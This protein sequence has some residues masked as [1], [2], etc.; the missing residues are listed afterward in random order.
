MEHC[1]R[2]L[3]AD[4]Y[5][6]GIEPVTIGHRRPDGG[7]SEADR[8]ACTGPSPSSRAAF[9]VLLGAVSLPFVVSAIALAT[10]TW[11][12]AGDQALQ[13]LRIEQVGTSRTPLLGPWSR[14][15]WNHPGPWPYY[16]LAPFTQAFGAVGALIGT[17][18]VNSTSLVLAVVVARR[19]GGL[20]AAGLVALLGML[21]GF[22]RGPT[23]LMDLWN[24]FVGIF[25]L[26]ALVVMSWSIGERDWVVLPFAAALASFCVQA[27]IGFLPVVIALCGTGLLT[28]I[29]T[30]SEHPAPSPDPA[31]VLPD[32]PSWRRPV[33]W[34]A[35]VL[36]VAWV[37]PLIEE[38]RPG[39]GNVSKLVRYSLGS[40]EDPVGW[41]TA[42]SVVATELGIPGAWVTGREFDVFAPPDSPVGAVVVVL[43]TAALGVLSLRTGAWS[44]TRLSLIALTAVAA[45]F[46][47]TSRITGLP[48]DYL[49]TWWWAVGAALWLSML[50]STWSIVRTRAPALVEP[51]TWLV[52]AATVVVA[53]A[54]SVR[55]IG[56]EL[57]VAREA[58]AVS[59]LVEA[60]APR[61]DP[62][63]T[64][65]VEWRPTRGFGY[66]GV[67]VFVDLARRGFDVVV[68]TVESIA[69]E[70]QEK[71]DDADHRL[72]ITT[73]EDDVD[74]PPP[75][76]SVPIARHD[77]LDD[78]ERVEFDALLSEIARQADDVPT[79]SSTFDSPYGR[80][81]LLDAGVDPTLLD[82]F[83]ELWDRG[84]SFTLYLA[85]GPPDDV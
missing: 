64:H 62:A 57:P 85:P 3:G 22:A 20:V 21:L 26:F 49:L 15:G 50:W 51:T 59:A 69:F 29:P 8:T 37:G 43:V 16:V 47:A 80:L 71:R 74:I 81:L 30:R 67:G 1:G 68:P 72:V 44:A 13:I 24:P 5:R 32:R 34:S 77:P 46:V 61:L 28:A 36:A 41:S 10:R 6:E 9:A 33:A 18:V 52:A 78:D 38:L 75:P 66:V 84:P 53:L 4:A 63:D 45:S 55:T 65:L 14:W 39:Q 25:P 83:T 48:Y 35:L 31:G 17:L 60:A 73:P 27:H 40:S 2:R 7:Q 12:P 23:V 56:A 19:R 11:T 58:A 54:L 82:R 70:P 42:W 79:D 76:G